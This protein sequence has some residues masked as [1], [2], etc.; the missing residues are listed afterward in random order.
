MVKG[1]RDNETSRMFQHLRKPMFLGLIVVA[2][3]RS[4]L[5]FQIFVGTSHTRRVCPLAY[6]EQMIG[7]SATIGLGI[8]IRSGE[9]LEAAGPAGTILAFGLMGFVSICAMDGIAEMVELWP[10]SNPFREFVASFV[11]EDLGTVVSFAY[12]YEMIATTR[13][14]SD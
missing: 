7:A 6:N 12:W 4:L 13:R 10:V 1:S 11:D 9:V 3:S 8:F 5:W 2:H 14:M